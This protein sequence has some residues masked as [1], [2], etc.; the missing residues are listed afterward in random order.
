MGTAPKITIV[1]RLTPIADGAPG[2][3][4]LE[5]ELSVEAIPGGWVTVHALLV[6]ALV[7]AAQELA[8]EPSSTVVRPALTWGSGG[9]QAGE[10]T[11]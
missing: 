10:E 3:C 2:E 4:D 1:C 11:G 9:Y 8:L 6:G 7:T 5:P